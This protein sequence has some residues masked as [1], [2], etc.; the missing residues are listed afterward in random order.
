MVDKPD[1]V[2]KLMEEE[3]LGK[4]ESSSQDSYEKL[5]FSEELPKNTSDESTEF[6]KEEFENMESNVELTQHGSLPEDDS[7]DGKELLFQSTSDLML[8][9]DK[10]GK[11]AKIN[12]AG[13]AYSGF[14]EDEVIG[15]SF[16]K[17]PGVFSKRN[18]PK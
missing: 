1:I 3:K 5:E 17:L 7:V 9:L 10:R 15:Q 13:I 12:K 8:F 18:I 4:L 11:I 2:K 6:F 14:S 16:W